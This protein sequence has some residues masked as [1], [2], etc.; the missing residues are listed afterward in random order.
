MMIQYVDTKLVG[1]V[2]KER[3]KGERKKEREMEG[4]QGGVMETKAKDRKEWVEGGGLSGNRET[5]EEKKT[6][7]LRGVC[8]CVCERPKKNL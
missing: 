2:K 8:V 3:K 5:R 7:R 1:G 4:V 6:G